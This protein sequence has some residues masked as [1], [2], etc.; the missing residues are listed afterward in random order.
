MVV[1]QLARGDAGRCE[2]DAGLAHTTRD[3]IGAQAP[4][5]T[6]DDLAYPVQGL[7]IVDQGRAAEQAALGWKRWLVPRQAVRGGNSL[8]VV[9]QDSILKVRSM[10]VLRFR[11]DDAIARVDLAQ[12]ERVVMSFL[13]EVNDGMRVR[14]RAAA[15][16][17]TGADS[18]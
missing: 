18:P 16:V 11:K 15:P 14:V 13:S 1:D 12:G 4:T 2:F 5:A 9:G 10:E 6:L 7:D 3:R 8:W 17:P